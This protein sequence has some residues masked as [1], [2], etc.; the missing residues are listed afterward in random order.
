ML[1]KIPSCCSGPVSFDVRPHIFKAVPR[2]RSQIQ[3][4]GNALLLQDCKLSEK[5]RSPQACQAARNKLVRREAARGIRN[6]EVMC[7]PTN[8][9]QAITGLASVAAPRKSF[10]FVGG[11][12]RRRAAPRSQSRRGPGCAMPLHRLAWAALNLHRHNEFVQPS[13]SASPMKTVHAS[14]SFGVRQ[15]KWCGLTGRSTGHFA[16]VRVW[17]S[18]A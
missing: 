14:L 5:G 9:R 15:S 8:D 12:S 11:A 13:A 10:K 4:N 17:A 7:P 16:A 1:A 18:K 2:H 6:R 3:N